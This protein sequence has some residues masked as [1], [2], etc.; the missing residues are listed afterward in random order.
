MAELFNDDGNKDHNVGGDTDFPDSYLPDNPYGPGLVP[1]EGIMA[2]DGK[3]GADST[4]SA[5][6]ADFGSDP[7]LP[8]SGGPWPT[9]DGES[10]G[11]GDV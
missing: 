8:D 11:W 5:I 3:V 6:G 9:V 4:Q 1:T 2:V 7:G 10:N